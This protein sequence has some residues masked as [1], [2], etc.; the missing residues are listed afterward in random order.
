MPTKSLTEPEIASLLYRGIDNSHFLCLITDLQGKI[1]YANKG[2]LE[3]LNY[4]ADELYGKYV[5][6]PSFPIHRTFR[7]F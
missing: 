3:I 6:F 2:A 5:Y 1:L 4:K 7:E